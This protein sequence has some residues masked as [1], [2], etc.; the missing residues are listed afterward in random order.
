MK[1]DLEKKLFEKYP[2]IMS[3]L[4]DHKNL[5]NILWGGISHD[6]GWYNI[7]D[8][9]MELLQFFSNCSGHQIKAVQI[10]EKFGSLRFYYDVEFSK[11]FSKEYREIIYKIF[12]ILVNNITNKSKFTCEITGKEGVLCRQNRSKNY[13]FWYKTLCKE[14]C[15]KNEYIPVDPTI[16]KLWGIVEIS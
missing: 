4:D 9:G 12:G 10:K 7:L 6:D 8:E 11:E 14:C 3:K 15:M 13:V 1:P 2:L 16:A 5:D